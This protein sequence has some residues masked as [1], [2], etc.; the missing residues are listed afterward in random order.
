MR[1]IRQLPIAQDNDIVKFP[2]GQIQNE[3]DTVQGTPVIREVYG[4]VLTNIYAI[5]RDAGLEPNGN[6]DSSTTG[7]QLLEAFKQFANSTND[8]NQ[9]IT[10]DQTDLTVGFNVDSMP[11]DYVFTGVLSDALT[12][13]ENYTINGSFTLTPNSNISASAFVMVVLNTSGCKIYDISGV[14]ANSDVH[15]PFEYP[16]SYNSTDTVYY[17][18]NGRTLT[19]YPKAYNTESLI[20]TFNSNSNIKVLDAVV[21]KGYAF[22]LWVDTVTGEYKTQL[23]KLTDLNDFSSSLDLSSSTTDYKPFMFSDGTFLYFSNSNGS[24]VN[25]SV[26]DYNFN[27]YS[28]DPINNTLTLV[29]SFSIDTNFE[30]T[31]NYFIKNDSIY[32]FIEGNLYQYPLNGS[33]RTFIGF[34]NSVN[35]IVFSMNDNVYFSSGE[36]GSKWQV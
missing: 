2:D 1:T 31:T 14:S 27:K 17:F 12:S 25:Q 28:L 10:V 26:N 20:R 19:D 7:Y 18:N 4:G 13:G 15:I 6:E 33:A 9:L 23:S 5:I 16:V 8:I 35:G 30:K 36:F 29:S 11:N 34:F 21:L 24:G 3:T 32:T 22:Y